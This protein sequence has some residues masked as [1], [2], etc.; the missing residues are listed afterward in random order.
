MGEKRERLRRAMRKNHMRKKVGT[1]AV[2]AA[3]KEDKAKERERKRENWKK[4][5][6][7]K[8]EEEEDN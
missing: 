5:V 8:I 4:K 1:N 6:L 3:R 2:T 7:E